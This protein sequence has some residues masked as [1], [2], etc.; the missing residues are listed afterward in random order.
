MS[1]KA[2]NDTSVSDG[3]AIT[4]EISGLMSWTDDSDRFGVSLF[5]S[6]S[7]RDSGAPTQYINDWLI[8]RSA[9]G[10]IAGSYVRGDGST[11]IQN[12]LGWGTVS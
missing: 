2:L 10:D 12:P 8:N 9:D 3:D 11:T 1:A 5:G 6:Y 7:K 4:P